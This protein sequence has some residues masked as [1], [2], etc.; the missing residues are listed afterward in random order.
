MQYMTDDEIKFMQYFENTML[1]NK[2]HI[3]V[4]MLWTAAD[5]ANIKVE[6]GCPSCRHNSAME[7]K[8]LY[9]R[10]LPAWQTWQHEQAELAEQ[11]EKELAEKKLAEQKEKEKETSEKTRAEKAKEYLKN[12]KKNNVN[13]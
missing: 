13:S 9:N 11:K 6:T 1:P 5:F 3:T 7:L 2:M 12:T 10:I 4:E 8:N